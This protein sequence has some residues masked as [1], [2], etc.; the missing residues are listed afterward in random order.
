[1]KPG[2]LRLLLTL[3]LFVAWLGWL[4]YLAATKTNPVVV[5][6]SQVMAATHFVL[7]D[8]IG[9]EHD[10]G[11]HD[12]HDGHCKGAPHGSTEGWAIS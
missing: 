6:R 10:D 2:R 3:G 12:K 1:M 5:S 9:S 7:A 8:R 4:G 11:P